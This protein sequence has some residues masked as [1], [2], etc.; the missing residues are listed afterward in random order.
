[1]PSGVLNGFGS[2]LMLQTCSTGPSIGCSVIVRV[3][4]A[5][6]VGWAMVGFAVAEIAKVGTDCGAQAVTTTNAITINRWNKR[7]ADILLSF[8]L[9][10]L[11]GSVLL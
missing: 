6:A 5:V 2:P 9:I 4:S 7:F 8:G 11:L 10:S 3:G 1:M